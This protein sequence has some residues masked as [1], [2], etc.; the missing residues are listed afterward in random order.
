MGQSKR[1][2]QDLHGHATLQDVIQKYLLDIEEQM[3]YETLD[4]DTKSKNK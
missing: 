1:T 3:I 2:Y 4:C